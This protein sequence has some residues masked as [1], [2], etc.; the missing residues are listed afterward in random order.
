[1]LGEVE[2]TIYL[3]EDEDEEEETVKVGHGT[4]L[5][6]KNHA[7]QTIIDHQ[8]AVRDAVRP[9][10]VIELAALSHFIS[11]WRLIHF[12]GDSVVLISP[13]AAS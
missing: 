6:C 11:E 5:C 10:W 7:N 12:T 4:L 8:E 13:Q 2:E 1:M 3:V 9:R